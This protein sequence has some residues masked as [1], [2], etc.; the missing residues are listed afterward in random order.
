M[1]IL[2]VLLYL[3]AAICFALGVANV[4]ARVS[5]VPLGL[6]FWVLV[7]LIEAARAL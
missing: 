4:P 5:W 7:P 1:D 6:L 3:A 2:Y